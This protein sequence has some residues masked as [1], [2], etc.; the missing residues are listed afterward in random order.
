[1][2]EIPNPGVERPGKPPEPP[3]NPIY[4]GFGGKVSVLLAISGSFLFSIFLGLDTL[5]FVVTGH[6]S[7][8]FSAL[9]HAVGAVGVAGLVGT[10]LKSY[11]FPRK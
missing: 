4:D 7:A 10:L 9:A 11:I 5:Q 3:A 8:V 2:D 6:E 1:M